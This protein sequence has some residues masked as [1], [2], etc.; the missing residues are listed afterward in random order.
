MAWS[1]G[2]VELGCQ[3]LEPALDPEH[4]G[5]VHHTTLVRYAL[6]MLSA[7]SAWQPSNRAVAISMM[8]CLMASGTSFQLSRHSRI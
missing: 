1:V 5:Q 2:G 7:A 3:P 6:S 4:C 8:P